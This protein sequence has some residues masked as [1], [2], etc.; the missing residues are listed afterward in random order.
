[1]IEPD[2]R[3]ENRPRPSPTLAFET[4]ME[5]AII[6]R[7]GGPRFALWFKGHACFVRTGDAVIV[8][9]PSLH[10]QDW[11]QQTFGDDVRAAAV[12]VV[13]QPVPVRFVIDAEL[14]QSHR[15]PTEESVSTVQS[16]TKSP[17]TAK[18]ASRAKSTPVPVAPSPE[19]PKPRTKAKAQSESDLFEATAAAP[20]ASP[21]PVETREEKGSPFRIG[22]RWKTLADFV[23]GPSNRVAH[24]SA[25]SI[26]EEPGQGPNPLVIHGPV[27]TGK[28]HLL[29][30]IYQGLRRDWPE[31][32]VLFVT[33]EEFT[34]RFVQASRHGKHSSFRKQ[35]RECSALIL[36]DLN[37]LATK[38]AT[39]EEFLH[40]FDALAADGR[41]VVVTLDC[42][43]R[44]NEEL[45]P[46]LV[47][48]LV[49]GAVW[50]VQPPD[51]ETRLAILRSK[52]AT[53]MP[54][55]PGDVLEF[56]AS[57]LRGNV[58]ELEGALH[59]VRHFARVT[60]R[61]IDLH[62]VREALG[63]L[64][65]HAIRVVQIDDVDAAV[66]SV[67]RMASGAL[68]SK[69]RSWAVAHPRMLAIYLSR[70]HTAGT[71]AE[72]SHHFGGKTHSAAV[73]AEKKVRQW[74]QAGELL[75]MGERKWQVRELLER[76]EREMQR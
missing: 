69:Q 2:S 6:R 46:E 54:M 33:A 51:A 64:L 13:G 16:T 39:Q 31:A 5:A 44:L 67:L 1:M 48:R 47:D 40:T 53:A 56:M 30:G 24:A 52:A 7:V 68:Q 22:R 37:F 23:V 18:P 72:I 4:D 11:L 41:Q 71:Y 28:T 9:V 63:E 35:F 14:F 65:R 12:E 42:H 59:S 62:L 21:P 38:R 60:S 74:I 27:G 36:D 45:M 15:S 19:K 49:G 76:I 50:G 10:F 70:K 17:T 32:R 34:N 8:G 26:V 25:L 61:N 55:I 73:A 66:C 58:R 20:K 43:P 3:V 75:Q 57:N 29:E